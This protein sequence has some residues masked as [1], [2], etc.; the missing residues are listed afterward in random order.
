MTFKKRGEPTMTD[1]SKIFTY[2]VRAAAVAALVTVAAPAAAQNYPPI[3]DNSFRVRLGQFEPRGDLRYWNDKFADFTGSIEEFD[4]ISFGGDFVLALSRRHALMFSGDLYEGEDSQAYLD[5][6]DEFG[7]PIVHETRLTIASGTVAYVF[8]I[9]G[10]DA[11]VVPYVGVG[12]G[13]Y[14]WELEESGDFIDFGV[15]PEEIFT[16]TFRDTDTALG[17]FYLAGVEV[18]VGTSWSLLVEGR[19]QYVDQELGGDFETLGDIDLS[20]RHIYGGFA[21][22]F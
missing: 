15:F 21:W 20:G 16:D 17:Y 11:P 7:S 10:R 9:T 1:H 3:V 4:D 14:S 13:I 6:I 22:R 5:F 18:P 12:G 8:S 19:W 2:L